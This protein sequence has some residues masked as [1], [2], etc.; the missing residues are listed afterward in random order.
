METFRVVISGVR[1][2]SQI[3]GF[4]PTGY[5]AFTST[6]SVTSLNFVFTGNAKQNMLSKGRA[7]PPG[8]AERT[9]RKLE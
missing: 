5:S 7:R 4:N 6:F 1:I 8:G 9:F 3:L 2:K